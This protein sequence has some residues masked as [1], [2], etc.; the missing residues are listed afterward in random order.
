M[1]IRSLALFLMIAVSSPAQAY[2]F[3]TGYEEAPNLAA[4][5]ERVKAQPQKHV[6]VYFGMS[7][8]CP[9]CKEARA[10]LNSER[11]RA[12]WRPNYVVVGIDLFAPTKEEREVIEQVRVAWAPVLLFLDAGGKRVAYARQ[13]RSER[14]AL[15]MN[16]FVSKREYAMGALGKYSENRD[17]GF[18]QLAAA[19]SQRVDDRPR[20]RDVTSQPHER[21]QG[22]ALN[23]LLIGKRTLKENQDWFLTLGFGERKLLDI[24]GERKDGRGRMKGVGQ[25]YVTRKG[26]LC[27]EIDMRGVDENWCRHVFRVGETYYLSKDLRPDRL[28]HRMAAAGG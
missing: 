11:V 21:L 26:K 10:I 22:A 9:P 1:Q 5:L 16:E 2:S 3:L 15:A 24:A 12:A 19:G 23:K 18:T 20:L 25:W 8:F 7:E 17:F 6:L 28:V 4:A 14:D 27:L 13:L